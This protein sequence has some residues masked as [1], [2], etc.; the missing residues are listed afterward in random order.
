MKS[1]LFRVTCLLFVTA[2]SLCV[3]GQSGRRQTTPTPSTP[4]PTPTPE[5]SPIPTPLTDENQIGFVVGVDRNSM[6]SSLPFS[7]YDA[8]VQGC[9]DSLQHGS[10]ARV[11]ALDR[12]LTR[13]EAIKKAKLETRTYTVFLKLTDGTLENRSNP[14]E[15]EL[16]LEFVVFAPETAKVVTSGH[17]FPNATRRGPVVVGPSAR[18]SSSTLYREQLLKHAGEDAGIRILKALNLS[19]VKTNF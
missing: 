3:Y 9:A 16:E 19:V 13:A 15:A 11:E 8:V 1:N 18:Q 6:F 12:E 14:R 17:S 7:Y 4:V 2:I 5:P 10:S